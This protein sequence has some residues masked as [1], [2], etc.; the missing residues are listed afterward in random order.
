LR[1]ERL[2]LKRVRAGKVE[3]GIEAAVWEERRACDGR[4]IWMQ[5]V[6]GDVFGRWYLTTF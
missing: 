3:S 4:N 5:V 1:R 6:N 2:R